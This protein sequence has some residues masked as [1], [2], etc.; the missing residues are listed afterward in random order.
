MSNNILIIAIVAA[1]LYVV[2]GGTGN[3]ATTATQSGQGCL[4][5][6]QQQYISQWAEMNTV[7]RALVGLR[8]SA[9]EGSAK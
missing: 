2:S 4:R 6:I 9:C 3:A 8:A 5:S 7:Q 1:V